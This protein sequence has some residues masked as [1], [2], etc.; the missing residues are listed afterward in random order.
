MLLLSQPR[1]LFRSFL[2]DQEVARDAREEATHERALV[3]C[4][5]GRRPLDQLEASVLKLLPGLSYRHGRAML[6]VNQ[7]RELVSSHPTAALLA[8]FGDPDLAPEL[9][10]V[11]FLSAETAYEYEVWR[12]EEK[13]KLHSEERLRFEAFARDPYWGFRLC[14]L[15]R[16]ATLAQRL[17]EYCTENRK[18]AAPAAVHYLLLNEGEKIADYI[19]LLHEAPMAAYVAARHLG[20]RGFKLNSGEVR[21]LNPRWACH[22]L[23]LAGE[24]QPNEKLLACLQESSAWTIEWLHRSGRCRALDQVQGYLLPTLAYANQQR[25]KKAEGFEV[26]MFYGKVATDWCRGYVEYHNAGA[27]SQHLK[28]GLRISRQEIPPVKK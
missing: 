10:P 16:E 11:V 12:H 24:E 21:G 19:D 8:I 23:L 4:L 17:H 6:Q 7:T 25:E 22:F 2:L 20:F 18:R 3:E 5:K 27:V 15:T 13:K 28:N 26:A 9:E 1:A 14:K